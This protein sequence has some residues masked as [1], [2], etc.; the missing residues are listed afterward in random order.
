MHAYRVFT[1]Q[2]IEN[3][4]GLVTRSWVIRGVC[5]VMIICERFVSVEII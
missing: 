5:S 3:R 4:Y 1:N 2:P